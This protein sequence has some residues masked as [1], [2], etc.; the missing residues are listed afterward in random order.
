MLRK[1]V[2]VKFLRQHTV[3]KDDDTVGN[4]RRLSWVAGGKEDNPPRLRKATHDSVHFPFGS[5]IDTARRIIEHKQRRRCLDPLGKN[6]FLL[7]TT[8]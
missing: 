3:D 4:C 6:N 1:A 5:H 2:T 8:R 7:V